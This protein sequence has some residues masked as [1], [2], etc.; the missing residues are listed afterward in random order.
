MSDKNASYDRAREAFE[1]LDVKNQIS[2]I[3]REGIRMFVRSVDDVSSTIIRD[4]ESIF[5]RDDEKHET[6]EQTDTKG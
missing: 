2:F 5:D 6:A 4:I 1:D 3:L